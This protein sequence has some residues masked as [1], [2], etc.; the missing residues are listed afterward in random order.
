MS[1]LSTN[2]KMSLLAENF[3]ETRLVRREQC[4]TVQSLDYVMQRSR[5]AFGRSYGCA[6]GSLMRVTVL[7]GSQNNTKVLYE[8]LQSTSPTS[9]TLFCNARYDQSNELADSDAATVAEGYVVDIQETYDRDKAVTEKEQLC[10]TFQ[11]LLTKITYH[12][13][14][15]ALQSVF[16][17]Q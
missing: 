6:Q 13:A 8:R 9:F 16:V 3:K 17:E 1:K 2:V 12:G 11:L 15:A 4:M 14:S 5:D 7:I 10:L